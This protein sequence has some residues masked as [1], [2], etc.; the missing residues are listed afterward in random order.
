[1]IF[2]ET[3][4]TVDI[5]VLE[6]ICLE[7]KDLDMSPQMKMGADILVHLWLVLSEHT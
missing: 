1:M 6:T 2:L 5:W 4:Y 3:E 7:V